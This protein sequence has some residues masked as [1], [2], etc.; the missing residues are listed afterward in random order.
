MTILTIFPE[1]FDSPLK[2]SL[3]GKALARGSLGIE[4]VDIRDYTAD[5]HRTVDDAPFGGGTG[6][7]MKVEPLYE[8]L[9]AVTAGKDIPRRKIILT[10]A[11]G[12]KFN[13]RT[14][15]EYS[16]LDHLVIICGRY[17]GVDARL[18]KFFDIEEVSIGD[19]V[20]NGGET[21]A[22]AIVESV[23]RLLPGGIGKI[24]SAMSDSFIEEMLGCQVWTRPARFKG[25][26]VPAVMQGGDHARQERFRRFCALQMTMNRRPD[27]LRQTILDE[28]DRLMLQEIAA[29]KEFEDCY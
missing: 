6:M 19:Y 5:K 15:I 13:Q 3:L 9:S 18:H 20:L 21:A 2:Q 17:K 26:S 10:S 12:R 1:F 7:V 4:L 14:A 27:L 25:E 16:L 11:A 8:A 22:L 24:D 29:G 23:F 28:D